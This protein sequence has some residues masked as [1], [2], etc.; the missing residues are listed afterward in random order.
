MIATREFVRTLRSSRDRRWPFPIDAEVL[1]VG[2]LQIRLVLIYSLFCRGY[3]TAWSV[4]SLFNLGISLLIGFIVNDSSRI[5]A[6]ALNS[7]YRP[8]KESIATILTSKWNYYQD[9]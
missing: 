2:L 6:V 7:R 4:R 9:F 1:R 3:R 8:T 5:G